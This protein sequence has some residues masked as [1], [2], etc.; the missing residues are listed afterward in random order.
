[1]RREKYSEAIRPGERLL[2]SV[3]FFHFVQSLLPFSLKAA[4]NLNFAQVLC[5]L[6]SI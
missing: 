1:M 4:G 6:F 2:S 3:S 5:T